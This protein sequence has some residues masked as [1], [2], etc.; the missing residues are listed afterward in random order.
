MVTSPIPNAKQ[1]GASGVS[2][3]RFWGFLAGGYNGDV[4]G[5]LQWGHREILKIELPS[6]TP[7][8]IRRNNE[9]LEKWATTRILPRWQ[10]LP[11]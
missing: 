9:A 3:E 7:A 2:G 8:T 10:W 1:L 11:T 6:H 5:V 4:D